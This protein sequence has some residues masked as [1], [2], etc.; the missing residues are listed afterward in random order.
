MTIMKQLK[1]RI[2]LF[3]LPIALIMSMASCSS[4]SIYY[5]HIGYSD[6]PMPSIEL[7]VSNHSIAEYS[8]VKKVFSIDKKIYNDLT[9]FLKESRLNKGAYESN[10]EYPYGTYRITVENNGTKKDYLL[11]DREASFSFFEKQLR[12]I[13]DDRIKKEFELIIRRLE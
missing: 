5:Q 2:A 8:G 7:K 13:Q 1:N 10:Q 9:S 12:I 4:Q 11:S 6:K 3:F